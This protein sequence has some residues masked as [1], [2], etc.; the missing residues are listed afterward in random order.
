M[1]KPQKDPT[2]SLAK[3]PTGSLSHRLV[4]SVQRTLMFLTRPLP[5]RFRGALGGQMLAAAIALAPGLRHRIGNNLRIAYPDMTEGAR[6]TLARRIARNIGRSLMEV[7]HTRDLP[8]QA[9]N[10]HISGAGFQAL[11]QAR[12]EGR[13]AII[14]IAHFGNWPAGRIKLMQADMECGVLYRPSN[15][16]LFDND[17]LNALRLSGEPVIPRGPQGM[18]QMIRHLKAGGFVAFMHDQAIKNAPVFRFMGQPAHT[19]TTVAELALKYDLLVVPNYNIRRG[20]PAEVDVVFESPVPHTT[21][22]EM[23]QALNDSLEAR[24]RANPEQWY[25]LHQRWKIADHN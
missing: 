20:D 3:T 19:A 4:N 18:R 25:W 17:F 5:V 7:M 16:Q 15:N 10:F 12:N 22:D 2:A 6:K 8:G 13:G 23:T 14:V 21:R 9:P 11:R 24:V 1:R